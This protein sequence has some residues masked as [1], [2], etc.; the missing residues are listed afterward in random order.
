[1]AQM[2]FNNNLSEEREDVQFENLIQKRNQVKLSIISNK[3]QANRIVTRQIPVQLLALEWLNKIEASIETRAYL[4]ENFL[5]ILV[6]GCEKVLKEAQIKNLLSEN[7]KDLNFNPIN[8]LAQFL[9]RNNPKFNNS[10][11]TSAYVRTMREVYQELREQMFAFQ[12]NKLA[13]VKADVRKRRNERERIEK[14]R[15]LEMERRT[16]RIEDLFSNFHILPNGRIETEIVC[17]LY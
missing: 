3:E 5:P 13:K 4:V 11:E 6:L 17:Y 2:A 12:E 15:E 9:M 16:L 8:Q 10:N 7:K 14:A 1:M